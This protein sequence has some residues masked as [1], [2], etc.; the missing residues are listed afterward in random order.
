[1]V[2]TVRKRELLD[3]SIEETPFILPWFVVDDDAFMS[4]EFNDVRDNPM[5]PERWPRESAGEKIRVS[6]SMQFMAKLADLENEDI[7]NVP[8]SASWTLMRL[9]A[10]LDAHGH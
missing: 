2:T 7:T 3:G 10:A 8:T 5:S 9:V 6:E 1:M 4:I